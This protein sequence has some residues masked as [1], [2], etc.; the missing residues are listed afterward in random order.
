MFVISVCVCFIHTLDMFNANKNC[1]FLLCFVFF[2][3]AMIYFFI[4]Y[5]LSIFVL[6]EKWV[7]NLCYK[8]MV[9]HDHYNKLENSMNYLSSFHWHILKFIINILI[10]SLHVENWCENKQKLSV[11]IFSQQNKHCSFSCDNIQTLT[12]NYI[13]YSIEKFSINLQSRVGAGNNI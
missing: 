7:V 3:A 1:D 13:L 5:E 6:G 8:I 4:F 9:V 2:F 12:C 10:K 11:W